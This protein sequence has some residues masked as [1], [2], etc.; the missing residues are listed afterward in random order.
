MRYEYVVR[1]SGTPDASDKYDVNS[2]FTVDLSHPAFVWDGGTSAVR[3]GEFLG[4]FCDALGKL[5]SPTPVTSPDFIQSLMSEF[6]W[7][8]DGEKESEEEYKEGLKYAMVKTILSA[9]TSVG[10]WDTPM[11]VQSMNRRPV[12]DSNVL[13]KKGYDLGKYKNTIETIANDLQIYWYRPNFSE[14]VS[15]YAEDLLQAELY[16]TPIKVLDK[17]HED[18]NNA[19]TADDDWCPTQFMKGEKAIPELAKLIDRLKVK[20]L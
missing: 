11:F 10:I 17:L 7:F 19:M 4:R 12:V 14:F 3:Y 20:G 9:F 16:N 15:V 13:Y 18:I 5:E 1:L 6:I 8:D 2:T